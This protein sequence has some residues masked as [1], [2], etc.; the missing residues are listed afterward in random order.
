MKNA[1]LLLTAFLPALVAQEAPNNTI[2][3]AA[4]KYLESALAIMQ[5]HFYQKD[6]IDWPELR[7]ETLSQAGAAQSPVDTYPAIRFA[8]AKLGDHHSYL[9]LTPEL[10]RQETARQPKLANPS[11][12]P[13]PYYRERVFPFPSPF[14]M[15]RVPES[16]MIP[17]AP[18]PLAVIVVPS[19]A[20]NRSE[21]DE[22]ATK[23]QAAIAERLPEKPCG[24]LVDLR[25]NGGGNIWAMLAGIGPILGEG[26]LGKSQRYYEDGRAGDRDDREYP[27]YA[28][29]K[30]PAVHLAAPPPV[31]VLIDRDTGSSGEGI[32]IDFVGR[33][34]TRL[35][36]EFTYGA[37]TAT[38]PYEL[39]DGATVYLV[40][41]AMK[42]RNGKE[43]PDGVP[44]DQEVV[45]EATIITTDPVIHAA[46]EWLA[47]RTACRARAR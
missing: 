46:S 25:G 13:K 9:Q 7:R 17:Q 15:R 39:S 8:L 10:T 14:R 30:T 21:I 24:W 20:G 47:G 16:A 32:A 40:I 19:F 1:L 33:P 12:M 35:F 29:T 6:R 38:F 22:Y 31:A 41:G 28:K 27:D 42:D 26:N 5:E 18:A 37:A 2:S 43:Y 34:E 44:P 23:V 11:A 3:P 36:G 4:A 45:S